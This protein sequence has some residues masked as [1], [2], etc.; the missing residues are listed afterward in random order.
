[1]KRLVSAPAHRGAIF[2]EEADELALVLLQA[3]IDTLKIYLMIDPEEDRVVQA[4]FFTYG[5]ASWTAVAEAYCTLAEEKNTEEVF[6]LPGVEVEQFLRSDPEVAALELDAPELIV[7]PQFAELFKEEY[8]ERKKAALLLKEIRKQFDEQGLSAY[9]VRRLEDKKWVEATA[10]ERWEMVE[11][12]ID[13]KVRPMLQADGGDVVIIA[14]DDPAVVKIEYRGNCATCYAGG[15]STLYY[16][17]NVLRK[18]VYSGI[19]IETIDPNPQF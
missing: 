7:L 19:R 11:H 4:R 16:M 10:D 8:A 14:I 1:M 3:K 13:E 2:Q 6:A 17:E 5:G 15:G 18:N 9:Q 12:V